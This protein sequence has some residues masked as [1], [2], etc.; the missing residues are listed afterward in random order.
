VPVALALSTS[1]AG[2][3]VLYASWRHPHASVGSK[4]LVVLAGW[5]LL[6]L[7]VAVW[8]SV[9]GAEF[10]TAYAAMAAAFV[11]WT[12]IAFLGREA[13]LPSERRPQHRVTVDGPGRSV[14]LRTL[15]RAFVAVPLA[16]AASVL[17][18][19]LGAAGLPWVV[20][21]RYVFAIAVAPLI[22]GVLAMWTGMT[23]R[24]SRVA[25]TLAAV[26]AA[27]AALLFLR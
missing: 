8:M 5:L 17:L 13:R 24:L 10:G 3:A 7:S 23:E 2:V 21:D 16:G 15:A 14:T 18:G 11:P 25:L 4:R 27:S 9:G 1:L 26:T 12:V 20:A 22:W 6:G 19:V